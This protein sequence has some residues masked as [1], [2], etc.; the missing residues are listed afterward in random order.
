MDFSL[1]QRNA[2]AT[3]YARAAS[4]TIPGFN[5]LSPAVQTQELKELYDEA[6]DAEGGCAFHFWNQ[7]T[8]VKTDSGLVGTARASDNDRIL[9]K[10]TAEKTSSNDFDTLVAEFRRNFPESFGW[11]SW[12]LRPTVMGMIFPAK[13]SVDP[14]IRAEVPST[15]N[16]VEHSHSLL[17]HAVGTQ[18]E[19]VPGIKKLYLHVRQF[20][21]TESSIQC[22]HLY[23]FK[24]FVA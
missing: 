17:H 21:T 9:R 8:R 18:N 1:A 3:A 19:T 7:A 23:L 2:H 20:Q 11:L 14:N 15:S 16:A 6:K 22:M 12:W 10:M 5:H 24:A 4:Q 13:S